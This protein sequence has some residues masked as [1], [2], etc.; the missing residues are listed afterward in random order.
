MT[1]ADL[2]LLPCTGKQPIKYKRPREG[3]TL[4]KV[5]LT[6]HA[7]TN[8]A[9]IEDGLLFIRCTPNTA[10]LMGAEPLAH[11]VLSM[12]A[13]CPAMRRDLIARLTAQDTA[14]AVEGQSA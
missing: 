3:T 9:F 8:V 7:P 11:A 6:K 5:S 13:H 1:A 12:A 10:A 14:G 2:T 4:A